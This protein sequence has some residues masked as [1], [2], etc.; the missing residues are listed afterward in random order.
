VPD[1][2]R[3]DQRVRKLDNTYFDT[4]GCGSAVIWHHAAASSRTLRDWPTVDGSKYHCSD[5][6]FDFGAAQK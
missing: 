1:G 6:V 2:V 3:L 4:R 5:R